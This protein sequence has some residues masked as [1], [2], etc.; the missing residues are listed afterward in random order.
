MGLCAARLPRVQRRFHSVGGGAVHV[1]DLR[2]ER[3]TVNKSRYHHLVLEKLRPLRKLEIRRYD[4]ARPFGA[5]GNHLKQQLRPI[6]VER[7]ITQF[8]DYKQVEFAQRPFELGQPAF[9]K[10]LGKLVRKR[11]RRAKTNLKSGA[12]GVYTERNRKV[13]FATARV[14]DHN[15]VLPFSDKIAGRQ[16]ANTALADVFQ[17]MHV[18]FIKRLYCRKFRGFDALF[19]RRLLSVVKLGFHQF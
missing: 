7:Q 5:L 1:E 6:S 11:P 9:L 10:R 12:A 17:T 3:Y 16:L 13:S 4:D 8:V 15:H 2:I 14:A 18:K 19:L